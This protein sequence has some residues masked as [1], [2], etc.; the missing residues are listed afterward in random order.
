M[1]I[2][3]SEILK[4][5]SLKKVIA[6]HDIKNKALQD[7]YN[8][9]RKSYIKKED[10]I[11]LLE[12]SKQD[13]IITDTVYF[14]P[15]EDNLLICDSIVNTHDSIVEGL[16]ESISDRDTAIAFMEYM[17]GI[18]TNQNDELKIDLHE[19]NLQIK[20]DKKQMRLIGGIGA[21]L[22]GAV[23]IKK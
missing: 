5:D 7:S 1:T 11:K 18:A 17:K 2:D 22:L 21:I 3:A 19:A 9:L 4:N 23:I 13:S 10:R 16:Q 12:A 15:F 20:Q 6:F 14:N 8:T